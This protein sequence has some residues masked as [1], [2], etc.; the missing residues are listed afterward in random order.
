MRIR[1]EHSFKYA[2]G[3]LSEVLSRIQECGWP[4]APL[5]DRGNTFGFGPWSKLCKD[6]GIKPVYGVELAIIPERA[7]TKSPPPQDFWT[8]FAKD[9]VRAIYDL[10]AKATA[11]KTVALTY[12][13]ALAAKGVIK[14]TGS[15]TLLDRIV[16]QPDLYIGLSPSLPRALYLA[17][18]ARKFE[19]IAMSDNVYP[20]AED[21]EFYRVALNMRASNQTYDQHILTDSEWRNA[22]KHIGDLST[23]SKALA[24]RDAALKRC[25]ATLGKATLLVPKKPRTLK[26][27][28]ITG[29]KKLGVDLKNKVYSDRLERELQMIESKKF[30]NYFYIIADLIKWAKER[31]I[32]GP[33]RGSSCGSLVCYLL[34]ITTIDPIPYGLLFE[35]F[36]D[37]TRS[38]LPDIDIDFSDEHR[39]EVFAYAKEIYGADHVARLGTISTWQPRSALRVAGPA[40]RIPQWMIDK[41]LDVLIVRMGGDAR[42]NLS[43]LDTLNS[44]DAGKALLA[45][46]PAVM[47]AARMEGHASNAGQHAAGIVITASPVADTVAVDGRTG[48]VMCDKYSAE[49]FN[50]LKVDALGLKQLSVFE[51]CLRLLGKPPRNGWLETHADQEDEKAFAVLNNQHFAGIFQFTGTNIQTLTKRV[52]VDCFNDMVTITALGRP[53]PMGTGG[54]NIWVKRRCGQ[55]QTVYSHE[56]LR[57][58]LQETHGVFT[59]QEQILRIGH[60]LGDLSW[61]DVTAL[62]KAMSKSLG[63]EYFDT[64]GDKF[65][66]GVMAK[67]MSKEAADK[68]WSEMCTFGNYGFNKSH[69]VAYAMVSYYCCWLKAYHPLEFAAASLDAEADDARKIQLLREL[70]EEGI[71]YVPIDRARSGLRWQPVRTKDR[72]YLVGPL[73]SIHG[74]GPAGAEKI[75]AARES[76]ASLPTALADKLTNAVTPLDSLFPVT[77]RIKEIEPK[78]YHNVK[79]RIN[80]IKKCQCSNED[81]EVMVIGV[82]TKIQPKDLNEALNVAKRG[83]RFITD[84]N[85][86]ALNLFIRD[87]TDQI[88][89]RVQPD[90]Y[91]ELAMKIINIGAPG[92]SLW[93]IKGYMP[94]GDFRMITVTHCKHLGSMVKDTIV[95]GG[96]RVGTVDP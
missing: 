72:S 4:A 46:Y 23:I 37:V 83:G 77:D 18:K 12:A 65:K 90:D 30:E 55:M 2:V 96:T 27:M 56:M 88:F 8:F 93:A 45:A 28:C 33:A 57:P 74:I 22:V 89:C 47:L 24:E 51:Q 9:D 3:L 50:L 92:K 36:I 11:Q 67:G 40:L 87:D 32:V 35:R 84:G 78:W 21:K 25:T 69:A 64:Y 95:K 7:E 38:D 80:D 20:R 14:C 75:I 94:R 53:G 85:H 43:L 58:Y 42:A 10:I 82:I 70:R 66:I 13:E 39:D 71:D 5:S 49:M 54:S 60:D 61:A 86:M 1:T 63:Q 73:T 15:A 68:V 52:K 41:L 62:R 48:S 17:A 19:F 16:P 31:M 6:A 34:G 76:G 79:A 26:N 91:A 29:A 59:Y 81:Q 44:T